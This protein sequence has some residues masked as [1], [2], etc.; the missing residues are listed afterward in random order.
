MLKGYTERSLQI[1][2]FVSLS[3]VQECKTRHM[4]EYGVNTC[5]TECHR[6]PK[7]QHLYM[8]HFRNALE[9][10]NTSLIW[11]TL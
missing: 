2:V 6:F 5:V 1:I 7:C 9:K 4:C 10:K 8:L 11:M 3:L